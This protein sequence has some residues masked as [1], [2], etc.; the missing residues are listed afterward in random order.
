MS[1]HT[2]RK[3]ARG[4]TLLELLVASTITFLAV[5]M[6]TM[7]FITQNESLQA[8]DMTRVAN[9]SSR[10]AMLQLETSLRRAGWGIDPRHAIDMVY[11]CAGA[12]CR[13]R[14]GAPDE[15]VF[16][17]RNPMYRWLDK[18]TGGCTTVG[19]CFEGNSWKIDSVN[20]TSAPKRVTITLLADQVLDKGRVVLATCAGGQSPVMLTLD[21]RAPASGSAG[22]PVT[23]VP[24]T[25]DTAPYN[26][27]SELQA[28]HDDPGAGLFLVDRFRYFI[29]TQ[30]TTE[31]RPWLMLDTGLNINGVDEIIPIAK[32]VEDLQVA[33]VLQ[34]YAGQTAPDTNADW[35]IG[36]NRSSAAA[37]ELSLTAAAPDYKT[38]TNSPSRYTKHPANVRGVRVS[39]T[40]RSV[41]TDARMGKTWAGESVL[42][43][44]NRAGSLSGGA[45]RRYI[46]RTEITLRNMDSKSPF[47][48]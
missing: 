12:G 28:C 4:F 37:E 45:L 16:V 27:P 10:D 24:V 31:P 46:A 38:A 48:F 33:Y 20:L 23:L 41:R 15:L 13:D 22:G 14:T 7:G 21:A 26:V 44:E 1:A 30:G 35:I 17:A 39:L 2:S 25:G 43:T 5:G 18:D 32:N 40:L 8:M 19:G 36:N 47:T 9:E 34:P 11:K 42:G 6:A 3:R 29:A